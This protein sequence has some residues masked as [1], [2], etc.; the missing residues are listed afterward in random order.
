MNYTCNSDVKSGLRSRVFVLKKKY[1]SDHFIYNN[2]KSVFVQTFQ[3][4]ALYTWDI[5]DAW[6][7]DLR[8]HGLFNSVSVILGRWQID[9]ERI[10]AKGLRLRLRIFRLQLGS[11][12]VR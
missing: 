9:N 1:T 8:F 2:D 6:M 3:C 12:L 10:C 5:N 7:D 11:N 4:L